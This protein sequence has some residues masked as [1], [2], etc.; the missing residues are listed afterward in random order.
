[1]LLLPSINT[2]CV[3]LS[4][5]NV[6]GKEP[7]CARNSLSL[8][9]EKNILSFH[10]EGGRLRILSPRIFRSTTLESID[11]YGV[12]F[13]PLLNF[14]ILHHFALFPPASRDWIKRIAPYPLFYV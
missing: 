11:G 6:A 9:P 5:R 14:V 10:C 8:K 2:G 1:M 12:I 3:V 13:Y 4:V 7:V